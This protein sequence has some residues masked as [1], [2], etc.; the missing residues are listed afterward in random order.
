MSEQYVAFLRGINLGRR[1]IKMDQLCQVFAD[2]GQRNVRSV[3]ASGNIV[4]ESGKPPSPDDTS[5]ALFSR[6]EFEVGTIIRSIT[7]LK[8][9]VGLQ[10]FGD[11]QSD[12]D[13]K[14]YLTL[15][16]Q[17]IGNTLEAVQNTAGDFEIV[18]VQ[19]KEYFTRAFRQP[20]GRFGA[21]MDKLEHLFKNNII[22]TRNWNTVQQI[23]EKAQQ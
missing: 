21:G 22:T 9:M 7:E 13:T 18:R 15:C 11:R 12:A 20:N 10:P 19:E 17:N 16:A 3:I 2:L 8:H 4:F 5:A 6:F 23:I 1:N 14:L